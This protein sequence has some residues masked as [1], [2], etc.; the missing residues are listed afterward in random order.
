MRPRRTVG[1]A[2][3]FQ[4][5]AGDA[6]D[7]HGQLPGWRDNYSSRAVPRLELRLEHELRA[8]YQKR[9]RPSHCP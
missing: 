1:L 8:W 3:V 2:V 6:I 4:Q 7:L 9:L 5:L